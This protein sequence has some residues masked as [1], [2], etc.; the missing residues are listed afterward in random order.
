M[1]LEARIRQ[2]LAAEDA[3]QPNP[4]YAYETVVT[5][6]KQRR[7]AMHISQL[8]AVATVIAV[9]AAGTAF[10]FGGSTRL[11]PAPPSDN[12][13]P[14]L[15]E[16]A[17]S[18]TS[19][20]LSS[21][22][23]PP[24]SGSTDPRLCGD[25]MPFV[26]IGPDAFTGPIDGPS[27]DAATP[28]EEGQLVI[29][30]QGQDGSVE[31]R[32]PPNAEYTSNVIWGQPRTWAE[33]S[34]QQVSPT[35]F[36]AAFPSIT[37]NGTPTPL[38]FDGHASLP[39][40]YMAGPCDA[41]QVDG[42]V[43]TPRPGHPPAKVGAGVQGLP[44]PEGTNDLTVALDWN[45]PPLRYL[46]LVLETLSVDELPP[47][48]HCDTDPPIRAQTVTD[49]PLFDTPLQAFEALLKTDETILWPKTGYYELVMPGGSVT[50][51]RPLEDGSETGLR[52]PDGLA[53]AVSVEQ[54]SQGW[55]V[56]DWTWT[57]SSC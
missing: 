5:R 16:P 54:T 52:P 39:S 28:A 10:V 43:T 9:V 57:L 38:V 24:D 7:I 1:D 47:V 3:L 46:V 25:A 37:E 22:T 53:I 48:I 12:P 34:R 20:T 31:L 51:G 30:W 42:Y 27:P 55:T 49:G 23:T 15:T 32:W 50:Y 19:T 8:A 21:A 40:D 44:A 14:S 26:A 13:I 45:L 35:S 11:E 29:H 4:T 33:A 17:T 41:V 6:G 2:V 56:T 18:T 36:L